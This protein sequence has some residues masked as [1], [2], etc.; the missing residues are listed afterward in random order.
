MISA[1]FSETGH[2]NVLVLTEGQEPVDVF[3][4]RLCDD[5]CAIFGGYRPVF[6]HVVGRNIETCRRGSG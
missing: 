3:T 2:V 6:G 1:C 5:N 4:S